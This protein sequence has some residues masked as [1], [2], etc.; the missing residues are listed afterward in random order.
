MAIEI[1]DEINVYDNT[2]IFK[3]AID[4][5]DGN[6]IWKDK[7]MPGWTNLLLI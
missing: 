3:Q 2:E 6:I 5:K 7:N 4:F 1:C